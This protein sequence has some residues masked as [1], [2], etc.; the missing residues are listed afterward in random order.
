MSG[1]LV[2]ADLP[3]A[4]DVAEIYGNGVV[5]HDANARL[6]AKA[7]E[8]LEAIRDLL[9]WR[10]VLA[11]L[12]GRLPDGGSAIRDSFARAAIVVAEEDASD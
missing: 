2:R 6:I 4:P 7:P 11:P 5:E 1:N 12:L 8:L 3:G 9:S 10:S